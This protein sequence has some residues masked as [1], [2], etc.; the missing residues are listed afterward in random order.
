[1]NGVIFFPTFTPTGVDPDNPCLAATLNRTWAVF[2]DSARPFGLR[3]GADTGMAMAMIEE[4]VSNGMAAHDPDDRFIND[5]Q[6]GIASRVTTS[7]VWLRCCGNWYSDGETI[8]LKGVATHKCADIGD[9]TTNVLG[10]PSMSYH[11]LERLLTAGRRAGRRQRGVTLLELMAVVSILAI[12]AS[13]AVPTYRRYL[14]RS[15]R[16][17]G[18]DRTA[19]AADGAGK[20]LHAEQFLHRQHHRRPHRM[21]WVLRTTTE[22]GK[23][24][25][26]VVLR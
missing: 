8:C 10:A 25:I 24:T 13:V 22:T 1:M 5:A 9:V 11:V 19:A 16:V 14:I 20:V 17:G 18:E 26:E 15:Q 12:L 2:L 23:Y 21:A 3:D 7:A 6:G 4:T